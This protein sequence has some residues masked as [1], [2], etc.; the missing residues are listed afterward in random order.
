MRPQDVDQK[1]RHSRALKKRLPAGSR[2]REKKVRA[3][4]VA[5]SGSERRL[6]FDMPE[7]AKV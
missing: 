3:L 7:E 4:P 2:S 1:I 5:F 6:G